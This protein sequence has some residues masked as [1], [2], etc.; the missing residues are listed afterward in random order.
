[1]VATG[2][3]SRLTWFWLAAAV[4]VGIFYFVPLAFFPPCPLHAFTGL[5]CPGCGATR[6]AQELLHGHIRTALH[7]NAPLVLLVP[8]LLTIGL[9][10]TLA[11]NASERVQALVRQRWWGWL[12]LLL[13]LTF[14][15]ARNI[16]SYPFTLLAP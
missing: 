4:G 2:K 11:D 10:Q 5:N 1:M 7:L 9:W 6:A 15:I 3:R 16:P 13:V 14:G 12:I 8:V